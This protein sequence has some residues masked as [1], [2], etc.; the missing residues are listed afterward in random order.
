M[1]AF[2]RA[3]SP[4]I[5]ECELSFL[6]RQP[7]DFERAV[8]EHNAYER[9]LESLGCNVVHVDPA[10]EHPDGVF[11]E[12]AAVILDGYAVLMHPGAVSRR[13]ETSSVAR[14]LE[15]YLPLRRLQR[16]TIDG[17]DVLVSEK[18]MYV[19]R[20]ARTNDE[21]IAELTRV[22]SEYTVVPVDFHGCLHLKSAVTAIGPDVLL[23]NPECVDTQQFKGFEIVT[24]AE[25]HAANALRI[26]DTILLGSSYTRTRATLESLGYHV[27]PVPIDELAK[28]EAG[29]TCCSLICL[30]C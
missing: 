17:G 23:A 19:G 20:S 30:Y 26:R 14:A 11:V 16:G 22:A 10:P 5:V 29:V 13:G 4:R 7:I 9:A 6:D 15:E 24:A 2:T 18:T 27:M 28:A 12:D 1:I 8:S 3:V 21:G 25:P